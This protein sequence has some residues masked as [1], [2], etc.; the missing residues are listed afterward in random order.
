M[1]SQTV[2]INGKM[3]EFKFGLK[4]IIELNKISNLNTDEHLDEILYWG[5][6]LSNPQITLEEI[7]NLDASFKQY[8]SSKLNLLKAI[9]VFPSLGKVEEWYARAIGEMGISLDTFYQMDFYELE[10][11]YQG[12]LRKMELMANL[13]QLGH[14]RAN[15]NSD[16]VIKIT[17]EREITRGSL[18][19]RKQV[20]ARL[21]ILED[22]N[23]IQ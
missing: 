8:L 5:F 6:F 3:F 19:E 20:F 22:S 2:E 10:L 23:G 16:K 7:R 12:Y 15:N 1:N 18:E 9:K 13:N 17:E 14:L 21:G 11:A 4:A